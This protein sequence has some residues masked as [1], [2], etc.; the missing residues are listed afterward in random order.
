MLSEPIAL[1]FVMLSDAGF[2]RVP[3][4]FD[5]HPSFYPSLYYVLPFDADGGTDGRAANG[6]G[7]EAA[8]NG[9]DGGLGAEAASVICFNLSEVLWISSATFA[10]AFSDRFFTSDSLYK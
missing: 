9:T 4:F 2:F 1:A 7:A 3:P 8:A 10:L 5:F 6:L